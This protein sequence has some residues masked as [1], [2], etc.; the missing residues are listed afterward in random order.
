M[1]ISVSDDHIVHKTVKLNSGYVNYFGEKERRSATSASSSTSSADLLNS[2]AV[3]KLL[4]KV[5]AHTINGLYDS[6][7]SISSE[8]ALHEDNVIIDSLSKVSVDGGRT[9]QA[10]IHIPKDSELLYLESL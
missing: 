4:K 9:I 6:G 1:F 7:S 5:T 3:K 2:A 8:D 10:E